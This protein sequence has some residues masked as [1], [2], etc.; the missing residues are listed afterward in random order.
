MK[1]REILFEFVRIGAYVKVSAVDA[2]TGLEVS[3]VGSAKA[4]QQELERNALRK[5]QYVMEK[6]KKKG[7]PLRR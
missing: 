5:L 7:I 3:I 2:T 4:S 1:S 6:S